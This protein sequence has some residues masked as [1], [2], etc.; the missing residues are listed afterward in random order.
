MGQAGVVMALSSTQRC[1]LCGGAAQP[2]T[3]GVRTAEPGKR[4]RVCAICRKTV[5]NMVGVMVH[6]TRFAGPY[7]LNGISVV[8]AVKQ[9][10]RK[11]RRRRQG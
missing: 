8:P 3:H 2:M 10:K 4:V 9:N 11:R 1:D 5:D 6:D 7:V